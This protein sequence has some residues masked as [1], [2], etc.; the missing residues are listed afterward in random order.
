MNVISN[1]PEPTYKL[2]RAFIGFHNTLKFLQR[3]LLLTKKV[4]ML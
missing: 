2:Q 1:L 4:L 3:V